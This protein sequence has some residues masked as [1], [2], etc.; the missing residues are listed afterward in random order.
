MSKY[1]AFLRAIN[2]GGHNAIRMK[3]LTLWMQ[4]LGFT[5]IK[6]HL[7]SGNVIFQTPPRDIHE[8]S[9]QI[10]EKIFLE[11]KLHIACLIRSYDE[12]SRLN[13]ILLTHEAS[14]PQTA[15][16]FLTL[17]S[18]TPSA[19]NIAKLKAVNSAPD[20]F[21]PYDTEIVLICQQP[22]HQ[23]KLSNTLFEK[24]LKLDATSR[25]HNTIKALLSICG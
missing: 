3:D 22:Y 6:T 16:V 4:Q 14:K 15:T 9:K 24:T 5:G 17:L 23:T 18:G 8:L 19:E 1:I 11:T 20:T 2:V 10:R 21:T 12:L 13:T 7:N 25:N